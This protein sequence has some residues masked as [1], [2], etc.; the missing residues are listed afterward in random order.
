MPKK[1]LAIALAIMIAIIA[2]PL[3]GIF[4]KNNERTIDTV[5]TLSPIIPNKNV[6]IFSAYSADGSIPAYVISYLRKLKAI[7][8]NIVYVTDN[9]IKHNEIKKLKPYVNQL[10]AGRHN[11]YDWGSYKRGFNWLKEN[12]ALSPQVLLILAND[13][14]LAVID[15]FQPLI[16]DMHVQNADIYGITANQ[17]GK[18]HIQ[19]FFMILSPKIHQTAAFDAYLNLV[20]QEPDGLTVAYKYEVPFTNFFVEMG[21]KAATYIPYENLSYLPLNDKNCYPLTLLSK[22]KAPFLKMRT[23][24]ERLN[25]QEPRR[26]VF[27][28]L[29]KNNAQA[30]KELLVHLRKINSPYIS[31]AR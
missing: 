31:D 29:K 27:S 13:S 15:K 3:T 2:I 12:D 9:K 6:A 5:Q 16:D 23:F 26:L 22:H 24:T 11:E 4:Q 19:S 8:P 10:I 14:T 20:K 18:Y 7:A 25:V 17:D 28:W 1:H 21:G 30:Y